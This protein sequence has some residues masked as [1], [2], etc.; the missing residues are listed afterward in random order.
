MPILAG[1]TALAVSFNQNTY[2]PTL[3]AATTNPTLGVGAVQSGWWKRVD[4]LVIGEAFI[5][6]GTSGTAAGSGGYVVSLP[7]AANTSF[8][9]ASDSG[10]LASAVGAFMIRDNSVPT[11]FVGQCQLN[12]AGTGLRLYRDNASSNVNDT[13]PM[14]WAANDSISVSFTY[15]ADPAGL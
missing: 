7:F 6:F 5:R 12:A 8:E 14:V 13:T 3:T 10:A 4:E 15:Q 1:Q 11:I 9:I 2:V